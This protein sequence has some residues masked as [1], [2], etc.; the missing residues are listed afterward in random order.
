MSQRTEVLPS[1]A[2][3]ADLSRIAILGLAVLLAATPYLRGLFFEPDLL[4]VL[5]FCTVIFALY[6]LDALTR[7]SYLEFWVGG[8]M[9]HTSRDVGGYMASA[10]PWNV[11]RYMDIAALVVAVMY[12]ISFAL[13]AVDKR[14]ALVAALKYTCLWM[15]YR[16]GVWAGRLGQLGWAYGA[17]LSGGCLVAGLGIS[18][19]AGLS[20]F[21]GA[22]DGIQIMSTLQYANALAGYMMLCSF[23]AVALASNR[24]PG[25]AGTILGVTAAT[26]NYIFL[27]VMVAS[28]SRGGWVVFP[29]ALLA[30]L[31]IVP[32]VHLA[33]VLYNTLVG[34]TAALAVTRPFMAAARASR[35]AL[36]LRYFLIGLAVVACLSAGFSIAAMVL[37]QLPLSAR[38]RRALGGLVAAYLGLLIVLYV[39]LGLSGRP[40]A[41]R[42]VPE[43]VLRELE[44]LHAG[45]SSV[46]SRAA[47]NR[48][49]LMLIMARPWLGGGGGAWNAL[50]HTVQSYLYWSTEVHNHFLQVWVESGVLAF[51]AYVAVWIGLF[52]LAVML[53]RWS[54]ECGLLLG[55]ADWAEPIARD[56]RGETHAI[57][58]HASHITGHCGLVCGL[59]ALGIHSAMDFD[60]SLPALS[61]IV[62]CGIG[63]VRGS[64]ELLWE[65]HRM[66]V[67]G[68]MP[69]AERARTADTRNSVQGRHRA[70]TSGQPARAN[71]VPCL[72][73]L[74]GALGIAA[75]TCI[76]SWRLF[77]GGSVGA[78]AARAL[79]KHNFDLAE[80][81]FTDAIQLDPWKASYKMD[82]AQVYTAKGILL[83]KRDLVSRGTELVDSAIRTQPFDLKTLLKATEVYTTQGELSRARQVAERLV[84][85]VPL[86][87]RSYEVFAKCVVTEALWA[88]EG[89]T[90]SGPDTLAQARANLQRVTTIPEQ[91]DKVNQKTAVARIRYGGFQTARVTPALRLYIGQAQLLL[92]DVERGRENLAAAARNADC[93]AEATMWLGALYMSSRDL[94]ALDGLGLNLK[95]DRSLQDQLNRLSD[96]L[97]K[98]RQH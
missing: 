48:D 83:E 36:A 23:V 9:H 8:A 26:V 92:G 75:L 18:A 84:Q 97:R 58:R 4:P 56:W 31:F 60:L 20:K 2:I 68:Y 19:A 1:P 44:T 41:E 40:G 87:S 45:A 81:A 70:T 38:H 49:A 22:F 16:C 35:G 17:I 3:N 93:R 52:R 7:K 21:P 24:Q 96:V 98:V 6:A 69:R 25:G 51:A 88:F 5:V 91:I 62:W 29:V 28:Q 54:Q 59:L 55:H 10:V 63:L 57:M 30:F 80:K 89:S 78:A 67:S 27:L 65:T 43:S 95:G 46:I 39:A 61:I 50:Y 47:M 33:R 11:G 77:L 34:L 13:V 72:V 42:L 12:W 90:E 15:V 73:H 79:L 37:E 86:D 76:L 32:R 94:K 71:L 74:G 53:F 66:M 14:T 82:L 64:I 85:L